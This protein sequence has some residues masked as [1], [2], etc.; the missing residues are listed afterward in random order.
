MRGARQI[1]ATSAASFAATW[2]SVLLTRPHMD[3]LPL[4]PVNAVVIA[5]VLAAPGGRWG[6]LLAGG[7][8]AGLCGNLAAGNPAGLSL[9]FASSNT[10]EALACTVGLWGLLKAKPDLSR[11]RDAVT[12]IGLCLGVAIVMAALV[13]GL[14]GAYRQPD[15]LRRLMRWGMADGLGVLIFTP[16][17]YCLISRPQRQAL[18]GPRLWPN[19]ALLLGFCVLTTAVFLQSRYAMVFVVSAASL[20]LAFQMEVAGAALGMMLTALIGSNLTLMGLGPLAV[21]QPDPLEAAISL[22]IFLAATAILNLAVV[23]TQSRSRRLQ[24]A[25]AESETKF[26]LI[27]ENA[28]DVITLSDPSGLLTYVSP[29]AQRVSGFAP[30]E[31]VGRNVLDFVHPDDIEAV[32]AR[33]RQTVA[34]RAPSSTL[35]MEFRLRRKD[36]RYIWIEANPTLA[37]DQDS[38]RAVG[39]QDC[40][41]DITE[42]KALQAELVRKQREAEAAAVAKTEFLANMSHEI[43]TPLNG[44]IGFGA[45]LAGTRGLPAVAAAYA[46]RITT[47]GKALLLVVNDIL[48]VSKIDAG[49]VQLDPHPFTPA[50]FFAETLDLVAA[51]ASAKFLHLDLDLAADLPGMVIA[52]SARTRQVLLNLLTNAIK[53]THRGGVTASLSYVRQGAG[54]LRFEI[55]DTGVGI[56]PELAHRLFHR[57]SQVDGSI[58]RQFGG[59]GLGLAIAKGLTELMGGEIGVESHAGAGSRFWFTVAAPPVQGLEPASA[60]CADDWVLTGVRILVVDDVEMNRI[61]VNDMLSPFEIELSEASGGADAVEMA[62]RVPFDLI[63]MDLQMPGMD[64]LAATRAIRAGAGPNRTTPIVAVSANVL[65][66]H[67]AACREAGMDDH[68][69]KPIQLDEL[70][71]KVAAW[72]RHGQGAGGRSRARRL[73]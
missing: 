42:R 6:A 32:R 71:D 26:R 7:F 38:G 20:G 21:R 61:L 35:P 47:A 9:L 44:I 19:L 23:T 60:P 65:P 49:Q 55:A 11:R 69:G 33:A 50:T 64:G 39:L 66:E 29:S 63:L 10:F 28:T 5:S 12:F 15:A 25:L 68:I 57:F 62:S 46:D 56:A 2:I 24:A 36:G 34:D 17:I 27:A 14:F 53:F 22:Q 67:V 18:L 70:L 31:L 48:D 59:T 41:R 72:S 54:F 16:A 30:E 73:N 52:D 51:Q 4:W 3:A 45:L 13:S 1:L 40:V 58:S 8:L 37:I 43:R